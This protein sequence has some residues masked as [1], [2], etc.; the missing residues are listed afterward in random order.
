MAQDNIYAVPNIPGV[1]CRRA[2]PADYEG[3][4]AISGDQY[5]GRDILMGMFFKYLE[6]PYRIMAVAELDGKIVSSSMIYSY[7]LEDWLCL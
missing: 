5:G 7:I 3:I 2:R 4:K 1:I 6:N